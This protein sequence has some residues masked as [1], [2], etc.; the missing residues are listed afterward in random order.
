MSNTYDWRDSSDSDLAQGMEM[1]TEAAREAQQTGNKQREA[2]F[3][4]DLN[5]MLDRAEERGWF[6]RSR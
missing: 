5:T 3:H 1:A 2:A 6:R 4:Q